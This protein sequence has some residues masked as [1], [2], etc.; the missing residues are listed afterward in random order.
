MGFQTHAWV[1]CVSAFA[2]AVV[3]CDMVRPVMPDP[4][5]LPMI[6]SDLKAS[7]PSI[8]ADAARRLGGSNDPRAGQALADTLNH[9][10]SPAVRLAAVEA[11]ARIGGR[12]ALRVLTGAAWLDRDFL[13]RQV[14][15]TRSREVRAR[16]T[17]LEPTVEYAEARW[18]L[19][20]NSGTGWPYEFPIC[21]GYTILYGESIYDDL[22]CT[23]PAKK[24]LI[25]P[26]A[27]A[28]VGML[29][30]FN[31]TSSHVFL[32]YEGRRKQNEAKDIRDDGRSFYFVVERSSGSL[33]GPLDTTEFDRWLT[34]KGVT[35]P[36]Q[37]LCPKYVRS[38]TKGEWVASPIAPP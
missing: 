16:C 38:G 22:I 5:E 7:D 23:L 24:P 17:G 21:A 26:A 6:L 34:E 25:H 8:R 27:F 12:P 29:R 3:S 31:F 19:A 13:V 36:Q 14:A 30:G 9:D 10:P 1:A 33:H 18:I 2:L 11:V 4:R 32:N 35:S 37:W 28:H 20:L 15:R